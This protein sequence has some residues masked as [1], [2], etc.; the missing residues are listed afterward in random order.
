MPKAGSA[1]RR[2]A[3]TADAFRR[4]A[5]VSVKPPLVEIEEGESL[6]VIRPVPGR[7]KETFDLTAWKRFPHLSTPIAAA[8][9]RKL[10]ELNTPASR[11]AFVRDLRFGFL[12]Y[13]VEHHASDIGPDSLTGELV[14]K[15]IKWLDEKK[16]ERTGKPIGKSV[17]QHYFGV[18]RQLI[19]ILHPTQSKKILPVDPFA[20]DE[21]RKNVTEALDDETF[22]KLGKVLKA[23]IPSLQQKARIIEKTAQLDASLWTPNRIGNNPRVCAAW[24]LAQY[25]FIPERRHL[26]GS[27][28]K[29]AVNGVGI[30]EVVN[31][32]GPSPAGVMPIIYFIAALSG[33]NEQTL[34]DLKLSKIES[35]EVLGQP[36]IKVAPPKNR[37][38]SRDRRSFEASTA[39]DT[40]AGLFELVK[41]LTKEIRKAAPPDC[42]DDL[43]LFVP[44]NRSK[45][46]PIRSFSLSSSDHDFKNAQV[47]FLK[48]SRLPFIGL[49][50]VRATASEM[51]NKRSNGDFL[52]L[53]ALLGHRDLDTGRDHYRTHDEIR[54]GEERLAGAMAQRER[55]LHSFG[56]VDSRTASAAERSAATPGFGCLDPCDSPIAGQKKGV[57]CSAYGRCPGCPLATALADRPYGLAR[58]LQ[59]RERMEESR[60]RLP[61][62]EWA[63]RWSKSH[64]RLCDYW[65][66]LQLDETTLR[67]ASALHLP[68]LPEIE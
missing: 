19:H 58:G 35:G 11:K 60:E 39:L 17:K 54:R 66:P 8:V 55:Y 63:K 16:G 40:V 41:A 38:R 53:K 61:S 42:K 50:R 46:N 28:I 12:Q 24:L 25:G 1:K 45:D 7:R 57:P 47:R 32:W 44:R 67:A 56:K 49:Q 33:M 5:K 34:R 26:Q 2:H 65:I 18:V 4:N 21:T 48:E 23:S 14:K 20:Q 62:R 59:L 22:A 9:S 36:K 6:Y 43:F 10:T 64:E 31:C 13:L 30:L 29:K 52:L 51:V 37:S 27:A 68:P 15:F 3:A